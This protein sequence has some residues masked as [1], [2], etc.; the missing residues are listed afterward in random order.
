MPFVGKTDVSNGMK[1]IRSGV[2]NRRALRLF[3]DETSREA[4]LLLF[5]PRRF[6]PVGWP[7]NLRATANIAANFFSAIT[8]KRVEFPGFG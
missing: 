2:A 1:Q 6:D 4:S 5:H 3:T 7:R 8:T